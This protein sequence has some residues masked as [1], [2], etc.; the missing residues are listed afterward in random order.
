[1]LDFK[2]HILGCGSATPTIRHASS[3][4]VVEHRGKL[5]LIDCGEG[6]QLQMRR[7]HIHFNRLAHIF[8]SHLH[9]DHF[10]GL[11]GLLSTLG[12]LGCKGDI[13]VHGPVGID[14]FLNP[15]IENFC[16]DMP[17]GIHYNIVDTAK[18]ELI[19]EDRSIK[20]YSIPLKHRIKTC[21]F[22]FEEKEG[23]RHIIPE[24][25]RRYEVPDTKVGLIKRGMDF[26]TPDGQT[27]PSDKFTRPPDPVRRYAYCSD[28]GYTTA[29]VPYIEGVDC[30]YH[31]STF[32]EKDLPRAEATFHSTARQA[33]QTAKTAHV[34]KL[35][36]GHFSA[37][38]RNDN[39]FLEEAKTIFPNTVIADEGKI[40]NVC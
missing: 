34:G 23:E 15:I 1:M 5:Y 8:I 6:T 12:M 33:A 20:V 40:F 7:Y 35:I 24:M 39:L 36:L 26:L 28:T 19:M 21:G 31:D 18:H 2:V 9:G 25:I 13:T 30:L 4:Q 11:P 22:L 10:F 16:S 37:R 29:I 14:A 27:I 32:L 17:F 3:A 38:Y